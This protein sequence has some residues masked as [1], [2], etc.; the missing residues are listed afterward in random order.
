MAA[1]G[2]LVARIVI[3]A[4]VPACAIVTRYVH[5]MTDDPREERGYAVAYCE[6]C[7]RAMRTDFGG[8]QREV[9]ALV[10]LARQWAVRRLRAAGCAG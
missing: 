4:P 9:A 5:D 7:G 8:R 1:D 2:P 6:A 3:D 10:E